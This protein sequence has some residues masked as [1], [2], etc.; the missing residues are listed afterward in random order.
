MANQGGAPA[1]PP[2]AATYQAYFLDDSKDPYQGNYTSLLLEFRTADNPRSADSLRNLVS[3]MDPSYPQA[4]LTLQQPP[5][6]DNAYYK[7]IHGLCKYPSLVG[8]PTPWDGQVF[9]F[10]G[11]VVEG[12]ITT[13]NLPATAFALHR[14]DAAHENVPA[15][16]G[17]ALEL[18]NNNPDDDFLAPLADADASIMQA[19]TRAWVPL[20][21]KY[22][23][24]LLDRQVTAREG[25]IDL[26]AAI[27]AH[28]DEA[29]CP[30][31][32]H[33][34]LLS[35]MQRAVGD[36]PS[37]ATAPPT[38]PLADRMLLS[39]RK[40]LMSRH[41]PGL[42]HGTAT[43]LETTQQR[44]ANSVGEMAQ[45]QRMAR[46]E[47]QDRANR[48]QAPKTVSKGLGAE[49]A[50]TLLAVCLVDTEDSLPQLWTDLANAGKRDRQALEQAMMRK[51]R[52]LQMAEVA[53][54]A[55]PDL[56]KKITGLQWAGL[57]ADD[58]TEGIQ[59]FAIVLPDYVGS[60][61]GLEAQKMAEA[62]D[63]L[64][65][66]DIS[67][68]L[69]DAKSVKSSKAVVPVEFSEAL[70][71]LVAL[72][73]VWSV[74]L[75]D[76]HPFVTALGGFVQ[77]YRSREYSFQNKLRALATDAPV[78]ALVLRYIQLRSVMYWRHAINY[79]A[80]PETPDFGSMLIK[81]DLQ[82]RSWIPTLPQ[83]YWKPISKPAAGPALDISDLQ[84]MLSGIT[85][86]IRPPGATRVS[87]GSSSSGTSGTPQARQSQMKNPHVNEKLA[88][89]NDKGTIREAIAKG[90]LP[91]KVDRN[92]ESTP[93]CVAYHLR[94]S[95]WSGC[96]RRADHGPHSEEEDNLLLNWCQA[97]FS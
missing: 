23:P 36:V 61:T 48:Q 6:S 38:V 55:T 4:F 67:S 94:G 86:N 57:S 87:D 80:L 75:G 44:L 21:H 66:T 32:V 12:M 63:L 56:V 9:G 27:T 15:T 92:G 58:L 40:S 72:T 84:S 59:P 68:S 41:L 83:K 17:R 65:G 93:M 77:S 88:A 64:Q 42:E 13:V 29:N 37:L 28:E 43:S 24:L 39:Q 16:L 89:F 82:D 26:A 60:D 69:Q 79:R 47:A 46:L 3:D 30:Q 53:P 5:G 78:P 97:A 45:E 70:A 95:C 7:V 11:D 31:L 71:H 50:N 62:Y 8:R 25:F 14:A 22:V 49:T 74:M 90:G 1:P 35:I 54:V 85:S 18:L 76:N 51:A 52:D 81:L 20:P 19:R 73:I 34:L 2:A 33:W 91:P 10:V 96:A